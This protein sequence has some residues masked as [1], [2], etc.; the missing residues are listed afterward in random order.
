MLLS[1]K[2]V[3]NCSSSTVLG[4]SMCVYVAWWI[5]VMYLANCA[6]NA[7]WLECDKVNQRAETEENLREGIGNWRRL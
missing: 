1:A 3:E 6:P 4:Y 2:W 7:R 5:S